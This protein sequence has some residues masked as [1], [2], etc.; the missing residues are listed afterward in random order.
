MKY[1]RPDGRPHDRA[2]RQTDRHTNLRWGGRR[3][4]E[5]LVHW[6]HYDRPEYVYESHLHASMHMKE[7]LHS[8]A[9]SLKTKTS[10]D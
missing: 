5:P 9:T 7:G 10:L 1:R 2:G 6:F 4:E 8:D 3:R